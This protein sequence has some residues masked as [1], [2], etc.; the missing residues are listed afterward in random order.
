[1]NVLKTVR[2]MG[3]LKILLWIIVISFLAA[4][5]TIWGGG[6]DVEKKG[7][8]LFG[9]DY[10]VKVGKDSF[11]PGVF[12]LQYRFYVERLRQ[13]MGDQF[14]EDF[15][16]G[17]PQNIA[18]QMAKQLIEA[19]MARSYGLSVSDEELVT[20]I[21]RVYKFK[22]PK[23]E[24]P[25]M[26]SRMGVT[27]DEYQEL[28]RNDLL[29]NKL[30]ALLADST[31]IPDS[32][33]KSKYV[34]ENDKYKATVAV[35]STA[36]F[37]SKAPDPTPDEVKARFEKDKSTLT[38]PEKRTIDYVTVS[39]A[40]L[41]NQVKLDDAQV[42]AYYEAHKAEFS[43]QAGERRASHILIKASDTDKPA[44]VEAARKQAQEIY[45]KIKAGADFAT[46][47]K[48]FSQDS[49]ASSGGDLGWFGRQAMVKPFA[50]A[51][52]DQCKAVGD[53][54]G[55]VQS[56]FGFH[57]IKLTGIGG[58]TK[59][60][61]QVQGQVRQTM[62]L[63][64]PTYQAQA[65]KLYDEASK[66]IASAKN[67]DALKAAAG[68][69]GVRVN[70]STPFSKDEPMGFLGR[71]EKIAGAVFGA[72]QGE[73]SDLVPLR[74]GIVRFKVTAIT[75]AHPATLEDVRA[76]ITADLKR[77]KASDMARA[78]A[79]ALA[80]SAKDAASFEAEAKKEN[81]GVQ[82]TSSLKATDYI[83]GV[84]KNVA[85]GKALLAGKV[86]SAVGPVAVNPGWAV[87]YVTERA[88]ADMKKFEQD[89][90]SFSRTQ[91]QEHA[92]QIIDDYVEGERKVLE[93]KKEILFNTEA[94]KQMEPSSGQA[95]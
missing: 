30:N 24:Y 23:T 89:K 13:M 40:Q 79:Y 7:G 19:R 90:D 71:D 83:P 80:A 78:A 44:V 5:F 62:L 20:A 86:N 52:F 42:R 64:D 17:A 59:P 60:F 93:A 63:Q 69:W 1:M 11:S 55:P 32:E 91:R 45:D 33:L 84:G 95:G 77:E 12:R 47:A 2:N 6:M 85:L 15:L 94:I 26:I 88:T 53:V 21:Q 61:E 56:Q 31:F 81:Y 3:F 58:E 29:V 92:Q 76:K 72:K 70:T 67:D 73:W 48:Q 82:T 50:D 10:A 49:S 51:V 74:D 65:K 66:A 36:S 75:P 9:A 46:L 37:L 35:V 25:A 18:D 87:G 14:K 34:E 28:F 54:V 68:K 39:P 38:I 22:D 43:S 8:S 27:A 16:R 4:M 57:I 41:R